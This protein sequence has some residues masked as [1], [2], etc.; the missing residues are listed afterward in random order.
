MTDVV[1]TNL[2]EDF[3]LEIDDVPVPSPSSYGMKYSDL[4]SSNSYTSE[5]GSLV[6]DMI[7]AN[8]VTLSLSWDKLKLPELSKI[9]QVGTGK[10]MYKI[11]YLDVYSASMKTGY[12][13]PNDRNVKAIRIK[14][15]SKG[16]YSLTFNYIEK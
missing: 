11:K 3:V 16:L 13:Y 7:R 6:R 15:V 9:L 5:T 12:F 1:L 14:T 8:Q 4:D 2:D 10:D